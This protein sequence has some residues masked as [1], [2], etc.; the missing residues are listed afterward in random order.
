MGGRLE[1]VAHRGLYKELKY[2]ATG[3]TWQESFWIR[4]SG[5]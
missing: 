3:A 1:C 4:P 5:F 2:I